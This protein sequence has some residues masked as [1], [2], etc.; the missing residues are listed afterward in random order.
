[1]KSSGGWKP[2]VIGRRR[3]N[4]AIVYG[5]E[6]ADG[7]KSS[8]GETESLFSSSQFVE[9]LIARF[10][11]SKAEVERVLYDGPATI[12]FWSDG[13]KTVAKR[14]A[15]EPYDEH[16]G[17]LAA[18]VKR[19]LTG[20]QIRKIIARA[21]RRNVPPKGAVEAVVDFGH[22]VKG[23]TDVFREAVD[24]AISDALGKEDGDGR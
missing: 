2:T 21:E 18:F 15:G 3:D 22:F 12:V 13:S 20:S 11:G 10:N 24:A 4:G 19:F 5:F 1:M 8:A 7:A 23:A 6:H 9:N 14:A 16:V 17:F